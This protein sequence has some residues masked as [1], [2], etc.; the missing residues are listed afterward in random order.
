MVLQRCRAYG[1]AEKSQRDYINQPGVA[2]N[3]LRRVIVKTKSKPQRGF[4]KWMVK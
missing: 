3:E 2:K 4:I 1:A